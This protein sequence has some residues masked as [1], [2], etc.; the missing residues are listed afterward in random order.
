MMEAISVSQLNGYIKGIFEA[1]ELL[2]NIPVV[3]EVFGV[4][5]TRNI[6]YFS[7]RD[8][9]ASMSCV[10]F[11]PNLFENIIEG[12]ELIVTGSPNFY[13]K[14]GKLSFVVTKVEENGQGKLYEEFLKLKDKLEKEG[15]F[16]ES[17]KKTMPKNIK[18]IGV[19]T[20]KEGAVIQDIKNV[21][22]RRNPNLDIVLYSTRVQGKLAENEIAH[23]IEVMGEYE[24]IDV[25][26]VARGGGSLEDLWAYNT[27]IVARATYNCPKPIVSAVGHE[28]DWTIIDYVS[29]LRAPTPSAAAELLTNDVEEQKQTLFEIS[30][31]FK[32]LCLDFINTKESNLQVTQKYLLNGLEKSIITTNLS[33][34]RKTLK[35]EKLAER[36]IEE[37]VFNLGLLENSLNKLNPISLLK[38]GYAKVEQNGKPLSSKANVDF[39]EDLDIYFKDGMIKAMPKK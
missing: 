13:A 7:L 29:D 23:A 4:S 5:V 11:Y 6:M 9:D 34:Q 25:I 33:L 22:W 1:E 30:N 21:G 12:K 28:T 31:K 17:H 2:H 26:V 39:N 38:S 10:C 14:G 36:Y 32:N 37:R 3:G 27:E 8:H 19:I 24:N 35:F 16:D 15:L 20:S 18:R